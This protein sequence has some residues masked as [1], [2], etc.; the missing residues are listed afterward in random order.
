MGVLFSVRVLPSR[1]R[2]NPTA[3]LPC[4]PHHPTHLMGSRIEAMSFS[5]G[6]ASYSPRAMRGPSRA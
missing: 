2:V 6:R 4:P 1:C 3:A 5:Q